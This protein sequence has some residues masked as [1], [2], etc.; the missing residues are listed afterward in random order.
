MRRNHNAYNYFFKFSVR[1]RSTTD[2]ELAQHQEEE[3]IECVICMNKICYEVDLEGTI[4]TD[5]LE[6][7][8][9]EVT[10]QS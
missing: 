3:H 6:I 5:A 7:E 8:M 10:D 4:V 9:T 2:P 1:A